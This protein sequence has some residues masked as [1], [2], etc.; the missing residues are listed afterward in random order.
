M[1]FFD[2]LLMLRQTTP[3]VGTVHLRDVN[4]EYTYNSDQCK[5]CYLIANAVGDEDCMYGRDFYNNVNCVD[6]D[7]ILRCTLCYECLNS[8]DCWN[9]TFL[10]DC[11]NCVDCDYGYYLK[12]CQNCL[13]CVNL[14]KKRFCIFNEQYSEEEFSRKKKM[15]TCVEI[16]K[17]YETLKRKMP[18]VFSIQLSCENCVGENIFNS[19][20]VYQGFDVNDCQ[21]CCYVEEVKE[22]KDSADISFLEYSE[23][24]Y[25]CS[26]NYILYN[27]NFCFMCTRS[28]NLEYC[29]LC[30][31][32]KD[33]FGCVSLN[34][35][36]YCILNQQYSREEYE[37]RVAELKAELKKDGS[38]GRVFLPSPYPAE[39]T[40]V[41]WLQL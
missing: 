36:Q 8:K 16:E 37:K 27:C 39:D 11:A 14:R 12:D 19:K 3:L 23:L 31:N 10:Q 41:E 40:V 35:K 24:C 9:C 5:N 33:C 15:L 28:S 25:E 29:E 34:H 4:S 21:D 32:C 30:F 18:R 7:H 6:C 13:G 2:A 26:C 20:N 17:S 38:Y 22:V 1:H